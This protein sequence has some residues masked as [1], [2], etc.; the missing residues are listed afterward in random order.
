MSVSIP[1]A[2]VEF[3]RWPGPKLT[4]QE[5]YGKPQIVASVGKWTCPEV[6]VVARLRKA[7][8]NAGWIDTYGQAPTAWRP[9]IIMPAELPPKL[10]DHFMAVD[11]AVEQLRTTGGGRWDIFAWRKADL[12]ILELKGSGDQIRPKQVAW[13]SAAL[14]AGWRPNAFG[15]VKYKV[16]P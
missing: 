6:E 12:L 10:R 2:S 7:G 5:N 9:S 4:W 3:R 11:R 8:W 16:R 14:N 15:L 13:L 1:V